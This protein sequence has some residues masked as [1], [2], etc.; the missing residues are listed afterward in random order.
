MAFL[1]LSNG[2]GITFGSVITIAIFSLLGFY[3]LRIS[4]WNTF[5]KEI[6]EFNQDKITYTTDYGWFSDKVKEI[7]VENLSC[8]IKPDE[9]KT[10]G[11]L[12]LEANKIQIE[13]VVQLPISVLEEVIKQ[14]KLHAPIRLV[15][16]D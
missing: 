11:V 3:L 16:A 5:G 15:H 14:A 13:S 6:I 4:L 9:S 1:S 7:S 2:G 10:K 8:L 12:I